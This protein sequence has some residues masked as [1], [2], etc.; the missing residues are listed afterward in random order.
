MKLKLSES[1]KLSGKLISFLP[2]LKAD[3][4]ELIDEVKEISKENP[5]VE[6]KNNKFVTF[7]NLKSAITDKIELL[8]TDK[9]R[10][11]DDLSEQ[12][13]SSNLFPTKHSKEIAFEILQDIRLDGYFDGDEEEIAKKFGVTKEKVE[14]IRERFMYLHPPGVGAKDLKESFLFQLFNMEIDDEL[15][16]LAKKM[17]LNLENLDKFS[18]EPRYE[19]ALK[20]IKQ[21]NVTPAIE[22]NI[23]EE[24]VPEIIIL[25]KD[26]ELE[27]RLNDE[28]YPQINIKEEDLDT[29]FA[30]NK[31]KEARNLV[32]ALEMRKAT[33]KKIALMIVELQYDFFFGGAIKPMRIK[34]IAEELDFAP[35]TVSRAISNKYLLCSRGIIPLK[36]FFSVALDE[37]ISSNQIKEEV[38]EIIKNE[39]KNKPL[40]DDKICDLINKKFNL[41]LVRR[42]ITKYREQLKL[43]SSRERKRIYKVGGSI[44]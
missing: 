15:Y 30:K 14:A 33:L 19:E 26:N 35:S 40:S 44:T 36:S 11:Y 23:T 7:T 27:I 42:T 5:F 21:F 13:E 6:V 1:Q 10:L 2:F 38:K 41:K 29:E 39:D 32:E 24:I 34:D 4:N 8:T 17:I 3:V 31:F 16:S 25:N 37:E 28:F 43:P 9:K 12:I 22:Y 18:K 20:I